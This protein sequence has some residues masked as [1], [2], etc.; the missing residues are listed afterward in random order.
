MVGKGVAGK[1]GIGAAALVV[2]G[3]AAALALALFLRPTLIVP[4][5]A[6]PAP[7][8][9][10]VPAAPKPVPATAAPATAVPATMAPPRFDVVRVERDGSALIAGR[11]APNAG[12]SV[13]LDGTE[14]S[15]VI[16][17]GAGGFAALFSV[18]PSDQP[19]LLTLK[20][21]LADGQDIASVEQVVLAATDIAPVVVP[22]LSA[23]AA[24]PTASGATAPTVPVV[25]S[26]PAQMAALLLG[27][28]GPRVL[29]PSPPSDMA[30]GIGAGA[31]DLGSVAPVVIDAISYT[32]AGAVSLGGRGMAGAVV[33]I[34]LD[35]RLLGGFAVGPDG[36][37]GGVLLGIDPG[38]Y[39]LRADQLDAQARVTARFETPFQR[40]TLA[41]LAAVTPAAAAYT[42]ADAAADAPSI[43]PPSPLPQQPAEQPAELPPAQTAPITVTVQPGL[44]LW[45][46]A[47]EQFG[48]GV[49][50][51]QVFEANKDRIRDP[52]L[53]YPGQ[54]FT[55][56]T[57]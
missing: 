41:A 39:T 34:Y 7:V 49:L 56:P 2:G 53:I 37:W 1:M 44:T 25:S 18:P 22:D 19:R 10:A 24:G 30:F 33:Q 54:V 47:R 55:L 14:V 40:E 57:P 13:L 20:M 3:L 27:P 17:D 11:A 31:A 42:A 43:A 48:D 28:E 16:A 5:A 51:V 38:I 4:E 8:A 9:S 23:L 12:V 50:Y 36:S 26:A 21:R 29:Q 32:A 45:A 52:D 6:A 35:T 46:I 15:A